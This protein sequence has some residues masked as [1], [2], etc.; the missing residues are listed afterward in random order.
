[1]YLVNIKT[2]SG[3]IN[4]TIRLVKQNYNWLFATKVTRQVDRT[5]EELLLREIDVGFPE[6]YVRDID[7]Y[8]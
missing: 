3:E 6:E 1:M 2:S 7:F 8:H 4:Q 5:T